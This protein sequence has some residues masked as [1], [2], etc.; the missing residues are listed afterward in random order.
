LSD[1]P[2]LEHAIRETGAGFV[3]VDPVRAYRAKA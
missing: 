3:V 1:L 2:V